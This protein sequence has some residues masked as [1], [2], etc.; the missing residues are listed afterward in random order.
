MHL[1]DDAIANPALASWGETWDLPWAQAFA[2]L[3]FLLLLLIEAAVHTCAGYGGGGGGHGGD[4]G[5]GGQVSADVSD[6]VDWTTGGTPK[7]S[8]FGNTSR[9]RDCHLMAPPLCI[10]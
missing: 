3:G 9:R 10:H 2:T 6:W 8:G 5:G 7:T 4:G 1:L